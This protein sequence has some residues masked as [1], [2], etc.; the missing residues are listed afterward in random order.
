MHT[1]GTMQWVNEAGWPR[2]RYSGPGGGL[3]TGPGGG[4]YTGP[5]GGA[6][7]G[8]G[9]GAYT[10][11]GGGAYTGPGG[12]LYTGPGGGCYTG[13]GGGLYTGPGGGLYTGPGGGL[14]TG[15]GGGAYAG[16]Q[17]PHPR[18]LWPPVA[19][20]LAYLDELGHKKEA[21][22]IRRVYALE[23]AERGTTAPP[24]GLARC[25][26]LTAANPVAVVLSGMGADR[27]QRL[28]PHGGPNVLARSRCVDVH[29]ASTGR[30]PRY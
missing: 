23:W 19:I 29:V 15:P 1:L 30:G 21:A 26:E 17:D 7:T 25:Y 22:L 3:Y 18:R 8:P 27:G 13:P 4:L 16:P 28:H 6:Y 12:G 20:L 2:D 14:Y 24:T 9:G 10:G 11:P 5:G